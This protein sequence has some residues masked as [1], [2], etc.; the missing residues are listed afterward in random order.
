VFGGSIVF[1]CLCLVTGEKESSR[2]VGDKLF[3]VLFYSS[4]LSNIGVH[5]QVYR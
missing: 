3:S 2:V 5:K 4:I 1:V